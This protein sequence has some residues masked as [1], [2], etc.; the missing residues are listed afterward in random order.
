MY[1][2]SFMKEREKAY[3]KRQ[4]L[5]I[6]IC[7]GAFLSTVFYLHPLHLLQSPWHPHMLFPDLM[8]LTILLMPYPHIASSMIITIIIKIKKPNCFRGA[9]TLK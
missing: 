1:E 4:P 5:G 3:N 9:H 7:P 2:W 6:N 8:F